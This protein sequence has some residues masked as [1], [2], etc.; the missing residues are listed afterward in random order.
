M[1]RGLLVLWYVSVCVWIFHFIYEWANNHSCK[2][3]NFDHIMHKYIHICKSLR[4]NDDNDVHS[5]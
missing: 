3:I 2:R 1:Y 5:H 4:T